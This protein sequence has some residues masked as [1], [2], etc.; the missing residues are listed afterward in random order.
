MPASLGICRPAPGRW[1]GYRAL[2]PENG[3]LKRNGGPQPG[4]P[5]YW[6]TRC[7][8]SSCSRGQDRNTLRTS[9]D[10]PQPARRLGGRWAAV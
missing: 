6:A 7:R 9:S 1:P 10:V 8:S 2:I 5:R 3:G 4:D